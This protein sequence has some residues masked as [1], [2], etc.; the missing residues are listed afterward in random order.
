MDWDAGSWHAHH[1]Q[2]VSDH[3]LRCLSAQGNQSWLG[4]GDE[5]STPP[6][7]LRKA[8]L[9]ESGA[10]PLPRFLACFIG[11][12]AQ[13]PASSAPALVL[14]FS[15]PLLINLNHS[16]WL[17]SHKFEVEFLPGL[18]VRWRREGEKER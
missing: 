4:A 2:E 15:L 9:L 10:E 12:T 11:Q 14:P 3:R 5:R 17:C 1:Q 16:F 8:D 6:G 7:E 13:V 18:S